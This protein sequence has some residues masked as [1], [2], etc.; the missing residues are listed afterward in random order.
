MRHVGVGSVMEY[1]LCCPSIVPLTVDSSNK[2]HLT[3]SGI[4]AYGRVSTFSRLNPMPN[5]F[6]HDGSKQPQGACATLS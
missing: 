4:D 2:T 5:A 1:V 6:N 3:Y